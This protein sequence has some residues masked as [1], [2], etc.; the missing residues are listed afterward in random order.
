[1]KCVPIRPLMHRGHKAT[2]KFV[3]NV[4]ECVCGGGKAVGAEGVFTWILIRARNE[5]K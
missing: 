3:V 1:M 5:D 4:C 2:P